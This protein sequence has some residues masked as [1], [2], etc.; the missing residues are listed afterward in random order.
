MNEIFGY[1]GWDFG[2][3]LNNKFSRGEEIRIGRT[4]YRIV[5]RIGSWHLLKRI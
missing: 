5:L 1:C 2:E 4:I 3:A